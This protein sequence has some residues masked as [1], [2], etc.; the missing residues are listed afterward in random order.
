M[1]YIWPCSVQG[2]FWVIFVYIFF[3]NWPL[4]RKQLFCRTKWIDLGLFFLD[5]S[6]Y[7]MQ[8]VCIIP[9]LYILMYIIPVPYVQVMVLVIMHPF[10]MEQR[11]WCKED[12]HAGGMI[13]EQVPDHWSFQ[14]T[15]GTKVLIGTNNHT[16]FS[17]IRNSFSNIKN[18]IF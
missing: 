3:S 6:T 18:S 12:L 17:N 1:G 13:L 9:G 14:G 16:T 8:Y 5:N 15:I 2:H 10:A 7:Y 4:A 11:R